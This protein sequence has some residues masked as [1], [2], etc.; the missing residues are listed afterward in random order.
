MP[1]ATLLRNIGAAA[2]SSEMAIGS[3]SVTPAALA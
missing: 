3:P 2:P 1:P